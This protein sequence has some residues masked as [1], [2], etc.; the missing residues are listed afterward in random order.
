ME[1]YDVFVARD[2]DMEY[3]LEQLPMC[4]TC[5]ERVQDDYYYEIDG[6]IYCEE[7]LNR[8]YRKDTENYE[9]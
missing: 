4:E 7:C 3:S 9:R 1:S 5:G 8:Q 2:A 6:C